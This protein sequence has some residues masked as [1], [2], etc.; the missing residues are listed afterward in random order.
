MNSILRFGTKYQI[1]GE[2]HHGEISDYMLQKKSVISG[3]FYL[4]L[5][6]KGYE[7]NFPVPA[8]ARK[9]LQ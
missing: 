1:I 4:G 9:I 3:S 6:E 8:K 2:T 5:A 7:G